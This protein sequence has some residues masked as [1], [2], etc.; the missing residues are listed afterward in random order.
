MRRKQKSRFKGVLLVLW[1]LVVCAGGVLLANAFPTTEV[2]AE[3]NMISEN[4]ATH[5]TSD[6]DASYSA[7][8]DGFA[9]VRLENIMDTGYLAL[10]NHEFSFLGGVHGG[11]A[12]SA[13][14]TVPVLFV[15]GIELHPTALEAVADMKVLI[16][17]LMEAS[18]AGTGN[19]GVE[20]REIDLGEIVGQVAGEFEDNFASR[21]LSLVI[22]APDEPVKISS[23]SRHLYRTL[24]NLFSNAAKYALDGTRVFAEISQVDGKTLFTLHNTARDPLELSGNDVTEQFMRGDK[25]RNTEGSGLGLYIAKSLT[26]LCGSDMRVNIWGDSFCV[27]IEF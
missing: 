6:E 25:A 8:S 10:V 23:D 18:K 26:E 5:T 2:E 20:F 12:V 9:S 17:D 15:D 3:Q 14:P 22:R 21:N 11:A 19:L 4:F 1:A 16:D 27:E 7:Q 13:W 24:E